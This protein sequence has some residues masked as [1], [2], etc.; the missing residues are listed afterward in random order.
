MRDFVPMRVRNHIYRKPDRI[1]HGLNWSGQYRK[2]S[3][4]F[5][6]LCG[7]LVARCREVDLGLLRDNCI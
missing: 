3:R 1:L 2:N 5:N 6:G 4:G 7:A